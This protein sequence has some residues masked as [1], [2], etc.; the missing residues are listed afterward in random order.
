M[1][2]AA[3]GPFVRAEGYEMPAETLIVVIGAWLAL[4]VLTLVAYRFNRDRGDD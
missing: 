2:A 4:G 3:A 1:R